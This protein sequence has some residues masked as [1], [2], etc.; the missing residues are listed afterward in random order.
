MEQK[1]DTIKRPMSPLL[2]KDLHQHEDYQV[3][4]ALEGHIATKAS[5]M[6]FSEGDFILI[7]VVFIDGTGNG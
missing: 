1:V 4:K 6:T 5:E 7:N 2:H 3:F